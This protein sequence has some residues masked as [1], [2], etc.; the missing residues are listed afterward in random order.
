MGGDDALVVRGDCPL[1]IDSAAVRLHGRFSVK[2]GRRCRFSLVAAMAHER[3][4]KVSARTID[5]RLQETIARW[6]RWVGRGRYLPEYR[7][8][9]VRSAIV[10]ESLT[11]APAGALIAAPTTSLPEVIG[12][13]RN[14]E[15]RSCGEPHGGASPD[16]RA[17]NLRPPGR[18]S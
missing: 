8:H 13:P 3:A 16:V 14:W 5:R 7:D 12:G 10:L 2:A 6:R 11:C 9:L 18:P 4:R 15:C 17:G 1:A